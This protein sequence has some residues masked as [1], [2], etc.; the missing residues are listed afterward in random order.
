MDRCRANG[1]IFYTFLREHPKMITLRQN[2]RGRV[3]IRFLGWLVEIRNEPK[4][5]GR[6]FFSL[7][8]NAKRRLVA[9]LNRRA[10]SK[11]EETTLV[12]CYMCPFHPNENLYAVYST[13]A[14]RRL[15]RSRIDT[16]FND[17][18]MKLWLDH[19]GQI[20]KPYRESWDISNQAS[21]FQPPLLA[22]IRSSV[23]PSIIMTRMADGMWM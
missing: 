22:E 6:L 12:I 15:K 18:I 7:L 19:L 14:F 23:R 17:V 13:V 3:F 8:Y 10:A 1:H 11:H 4:Y 20:F 5:D 16:V 21:P 9:I 2:S